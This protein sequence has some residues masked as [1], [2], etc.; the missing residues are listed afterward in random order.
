MDELKN[1]AKMQVLEEIMQMMTDKMDEGLKSKSPKF[2]KVSVMGKDKDSVE[3]GLDK[4]EELMQESDDESKSMFN[5][6]P[7]GESDDDEDLERLK[8]LYSRLK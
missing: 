3:Q 1:K 5:T 4:A 6:T 2:M 7:A 8:E